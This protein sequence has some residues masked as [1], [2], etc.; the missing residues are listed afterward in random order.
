MTIAKKYIKLE[1]ITG[2]IDGEDFLYIMIYYVMTFFDKYV[3]NIPGT[4]LEDLN[5]QYPEVI[6]K[7]K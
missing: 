5:D 7:S 2:S 4:M 1:G 3:K 6:F